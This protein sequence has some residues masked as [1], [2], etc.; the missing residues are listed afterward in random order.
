[1]LNIYACIRFTGHILIYTG[2]VMVYTQVHSSN[3]DNSPE[4]ASRP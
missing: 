1:M 2:K 4:T 3:V